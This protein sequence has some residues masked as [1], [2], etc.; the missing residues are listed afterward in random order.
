MFSEWS[1]IIKKKKLRH[2][3][4]WIN[5]YKTNTKFLK[6][7]EAPNNKRFR[8]Y[9]THNID[10]N[11]S[12]QILKWYNGLTNHFKTDFSYDGLSINLLK[13]VLIK[14]FTTI[15]KT[16]TTKFVAAKHEIPFFL[17]KNT[18]TSCP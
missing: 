6:P 3:L 9:L 10:N 18:C 7:Y 4:S 1:L 14:P 5:I 2:I 12:F 13:D 16:E 15:V 17:R 8:K 11:F